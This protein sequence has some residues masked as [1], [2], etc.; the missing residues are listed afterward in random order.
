[1]SL[2]N[3]E[4]ENLWGDVVPSRVVF[5]IRLGCAPLHT[6]TLS[7]LS[8]SLSPPFPSKCRSF[9]LGK[10]DQNEYLTCAR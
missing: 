6:N 9:S 5:K 7:P 3:Q 4:S 8:R 2:K 1:M 10:N